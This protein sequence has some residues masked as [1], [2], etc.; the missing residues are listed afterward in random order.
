MYKSDIPSLIQLNFFNI[1]FK[2]KKDNVVS[3][4][5]QAFP[6]NML[7]NF[8]KCIERSRGWLHGML[9][10]L[11]E[12]I[13]ENNIRYMIQGG[14][15]SN[16]HQ[17]V[18]VNPLYYLYIRG[19]PQNYNEETATNAAN[20]LYLD[21]LLRSPSEEEKK[22][23]V[24]ELMNDKINPVLK[25]ES[26]KRLDEYQKMVEPITKQLKECY[27]EMIGYIDERAINNDSELILK[28]KNTINDIYSRYCSHGAYRHLYKTE[29]QAM[30][31]QVKAIWHIFRNSLYKTHI[32][33]KELREGKI[34]EL[35]V[36]RRVEELLLI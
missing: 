32:I 13:G 27:L 18:N 1:C 22:R 11:K 31:R 29:Q 19:V 30:D 36:P 5:M 24:W 14:Y 23:Y 17:N 8:R 16:A 20:E 6:G 28:K 21:V 10:D 35:D 25:R 12:L 34:T 9:P 33:A 2:D 3:D 26:L 15:D 4:I 7:V